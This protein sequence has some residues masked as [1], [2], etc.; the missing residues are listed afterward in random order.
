ML[1]GIVGLMGGGKTLLMTILSYIF[2][3]KTNLSVEANYSLKFGS[4]F[5]PMEL[6]TFPDI[7]NVIQ[8]IN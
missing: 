3:I 2:H 5:N 1:I 6:T 4:R 7:N 8:C